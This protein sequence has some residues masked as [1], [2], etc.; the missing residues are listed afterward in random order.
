[1]NTTPTPRR[2]RVLTAAT[3]ALALATG[4]WLPPSQA[5]ADPTFL[6]AFD[7]F[8]RASDG[9]A[10]LIERSA[11]EFA[12]LLAAQPANPVMLAYAGASTAMESRV[13]MLPWKKMGYAEDG[14]AQLDKALGMLTAAHDAPLEHQTPGT[15]E[16]RFVAASTFLAVPDFMNRGA[17]GAKLLGDVLGSPLFASAPVAFRGQVWMRAATLAAKEKRY[18]DARRL[19]GAVVAAGAP[20]ADAARAK[21][22]ELSA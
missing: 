22:R 2:A 9:D 15:L 18:D 5:A 3:A 10:S 4:L 20:Q 6:A 7:D 13:T 14:L 21:L 17:R 1:M 19:L 16:V 8:S 11:Q 12:V